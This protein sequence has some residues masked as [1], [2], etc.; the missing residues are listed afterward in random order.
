[1]TKWQTILVGDERLQFP[2]DMPDEEI[3]RVIKADLDEQKSEEI[4][5]YLKENGWDLDQEENND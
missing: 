5:Q 3:V 1:M 2:A 4:K